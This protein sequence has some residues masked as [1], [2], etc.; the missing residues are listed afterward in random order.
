M[1]SPEQIAYMQRASNFVDGLALNSAIT[2][3]P[4][5]YQSMCFEG[6][7]TIRLAN[8]YRPKIYCVPDQ[9]TFGYP[10]PLGGAPPPGSNGMFPFTD[11]MTQVRMLPGTVVLGMTL[12]NVGGD[13]GYPFGFNLAD[14]FYISVEDDATGVPFFSDWIAELMFNVPVLW[15]SVARANVF[16][17]V[18]KTCWLPLTRPRVIEAPGTITVKGCYKATPGSSINISP[19]LILHCAEP[20]SVIR[21]ISECE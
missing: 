21:G 9:S 10:L 1:P 18:A 19:Q 11:F 14:N 20:C 16:D 12:A 6:L 13:G 4:Y 3:S 7:N 2:P 17:Y 15:N 5:C 8:N